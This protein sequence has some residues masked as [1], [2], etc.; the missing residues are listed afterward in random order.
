M[1]QIQLYAIANGYDN[2]TLRTAP[3]AEL[4]LLRLQP[5][6]AALEAAA[7]ARATAANTPE[8]Y[9]EYLAKH[10]NGLN[11][12]EARRRQSE[13]LSAQERSAWENSLP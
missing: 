1:A 3:S 4:P 11:A 9:G 5:S 2:A 8:A 7:W 12:A 6:A 10:P 13:G